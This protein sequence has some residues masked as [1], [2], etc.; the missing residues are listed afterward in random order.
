MMKKILGI[1]TC[2]NRKEKTVTCLKSLQ[3]GN[4]SLEFAFL[5]VDDASTDGTYEELKKHRN[6]EVIRGDG[7]LYYSGGMRKGI[8]EAKEKYFGY[9]YCL[10]FNDDVD[11][12]PQTIERMIQENTDA[13]QIVVGA[14]CNQR[15]KL[16]YG[17]A[18]KK[19]RFRPSFQIIMSGERWAEC[20]TFNANCVLIPYDTFLKL[21]N[22]DKKYTHSLGDFDYGLTAK[23]MNCRIN[24]TSFFV[25]VCNENPIEKTWK[26][27]SLCRSERRKLKESPKGLPSGEWFYFVNKHFGFI[28]ACYSFLVSYIRIFLKI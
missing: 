12:Y 6:V 17:G 21:P 27:S 23:R 5:A 25:G 13:S 18:V 4:P 11:F 1:F 20:D 3:E 28:S 10:F 2:Y 19:S 8:E 22:M 9:D 24:P 15:G 7:K 26:D 16:T 14:T